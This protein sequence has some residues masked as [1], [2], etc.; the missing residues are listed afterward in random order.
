MKQLTDYSGEF[1]PDL[2]FTDFSYD[3]LVKLLELYCKFYW[4]MD[5][6]WFLSIK[7]RINA[8]EALTCDLMTLEK[9]ARYEM[10]KIT[11]KFNIAGNDVIPLM[12]AI[13]LTPWYRQNQ[14]EIDIKDGGNA[15]LTITHCPTL[16]ALEKEG[17]ARESEICNVVEPKVLKFYASFFNP[18]ISVKCLKSP[19]RQSE[20][21]I[22]CQWEFSIEDK[23]G[24]NEAL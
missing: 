13:Q 11:E 14:F 12:K 19:P 6:N 7:E 4:A 18:H 3:T 22:C 23:M 17:K 8:E 15:I 21:D 5:G 1:N 9:M 10:A 20:S 16:Q 24:S 2:R